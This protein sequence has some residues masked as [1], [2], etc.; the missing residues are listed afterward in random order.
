MNNVFWMLN[1]RQYRTDIS[2]KRKKDKGNNMNAMD[3]FL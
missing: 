2:E 1:K 3:F